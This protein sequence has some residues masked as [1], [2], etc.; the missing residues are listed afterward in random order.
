MRI[1]EILQNKDEQAN[2]NLGDP[3]AFLNVFDPEKEAEKVGDF[4]AEG[5][6]PEQVE[7]T[8][9]QA[10]GNK[11]DN[12]GDWMLTLFGGGE[13]SKPAESSAAP[14]A[15]SK[16]STFEHDWVCCHFWCRRNRITIANINLDCAFSAVNRAYDCDSCT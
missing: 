14:A 5:L 15:E 13:A 16:G 3:S 7:T 8:L 11:Q 4:M 1:L 10:A 12:E 2:K 9:D 6:T